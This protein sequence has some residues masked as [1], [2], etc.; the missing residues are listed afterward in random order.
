MKSI[1]VSF[2][3]IS[4][5]SGFALGQEMTDISVR[6]LIGIKTDEIMK[7]NVF[8]YAMLWGESNP[9]LQDLL[10][11]KPIRKDG[12]G[13][14]LQATQVA[15]IDPNISGKNHTDLSATVRAAK[16]ID[17]TCVS[18]ILLADA[19]GYRSQ[20][21]CTIKTV[22]KNFVQREIYGNGYTVD[23]SYGNIDFGHS[24]D[25]ISFIA[26]YSPDGKLRHFNNLMNL[27]Q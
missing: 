23:S 8:D 27:M 9:S 6:D 5:I 18:N 14:L 26:I 20:P 10:S 25:G 21:L 7:R 15:K 4:S 17:K 24:R 19:A 16:T 13:N 22:D 11:G 3:V 12:S 2:A 1:F